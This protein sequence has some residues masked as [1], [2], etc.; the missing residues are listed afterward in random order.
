MSEQRQNWAGNYTYQA[1]G[2]Q[3]PESIEELQE[4]VVKSDKLKALGSRHSFN[5]IADTSSQQVSLSK[6]NIETSFDRERKQVTFGAGLTYGQL[7]PL[8][9]AQGFALHNLASLPH[10][11][12]VGSV[13]TATHGS[14]DNNGNLAVGV[15]AI[16]FVSG[17]GELVSLSR[18]GNPDI[19][20]GVVVHL[21][22]LGIITKMTL[23]LQPSFSVQQDVYDRLPLSELYANFDAIESSAY[24]VSLFSDWHPDYVKQVW[25]KH[26]LSSSEGQPIEPTFYGATLAQQQRHPVDDAAAVSVTPQRG[27]P[28]PWHERLPHFRIDQTPS[29]GAEIQ[30]EYFVPRKYAVEAYKAINALGEQ[31]RPVLLISEIRT[32]AA[33]NLWMSTAYQQPMVGFHFTWKR[34][35]DG[36]KARLPLIEAAL[37][38]FECRPHWGKTFTM[39]PERIRSFYP[40]LGDFL[41]LCQRF[42]PQGKFRN[43]YLDKVLFS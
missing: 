28:G 27:I 2:I 43:A 17:T 21:G 18:E 11:S 32:V 14:G 12:V 4:L 22:A 38:P 9:E 23:E 5:D 33:D 6:L 35:W 36:V 20:N 1:R 26:R 19:F 37:E 10:I 39:A 34:D 42:D 24:S 8:I 40:K 7:C 16:E 30:S 29:V 3:Y 13:A 31:I 15:T 41:A 25:L